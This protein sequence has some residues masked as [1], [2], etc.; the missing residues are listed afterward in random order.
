MSGDVDD[1]EFGAEL[2]A[3]AR[4][5][6]AADTR[7]LVDDEP[8]SDARSDDA[9]LERALDELARDAPV[10]PLSSRRTWIAAAAVLAA[11]VVAAILMWPRDPALP[12]YEERVFEGGMAEVRSD[13]SREAVFLPST[14]IRWSFAPHEEVSEPI[15]LRILAKGPTRRCIAVEH[16]QRISPTG[17]VE[18]EGPIGEV[19]GLE[20]GLWTLTAIVG[21]R[22]SI[23]A[24]EDPCSPDGEALV[25]VAT[26]EISIEAR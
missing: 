8:P 11:I 10:V 6:W 18:I 17:A 5:R 25:A 23:D 3:R 1:D 24:A 9:L 22:A 4:E 26:R 13:P 16:G 2:E 12:A 15:A 19:L 21:A 7:A 14:R 20:P